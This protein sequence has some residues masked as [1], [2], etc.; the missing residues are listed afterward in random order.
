MH[1]RTSPE[2]RHRFC[3]YTDVHRK[4]A[5]DVVVAVL[6][7]RS[8]G[9]HIPIQ[10]PP[11]SPQSSYLRYP[12]V[13][14]G[15]APHSLGPEA[16]L[17]WGIFLGTRSPMSVPMVLKRCSPGSISAYYEARPPE[18]LMSLRQLWLAY[19]G[20]RASCRSS[21]VSP[22][23]HCLT[24]CRCCPSTASLDPSPTPGTVGLGY[25]VCRP[26]ACLMALVQSFLMAIHTQYTIIMY[27]DATR[28]VP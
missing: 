9:S 17:I 12:T 2:L 22:V 18:S 28:C 25:I 15:L 7:H 5:S 24:A 19:F 14:R 16:L 11:R 20:R 3:L 27:G 1:H 23:T 8:C 10:A 26:F 6:R 21:N 4:S 13:F